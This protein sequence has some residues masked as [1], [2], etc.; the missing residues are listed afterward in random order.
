Y[1][2]SASPHGRSGN[3]VQL[4]YCP[5]HPEWKKIVDDD[6]PHFTEVA[7][8]ISEQNTEC[9]GCDEFVDWFTTCQASTI[10]YYGFGWWAWDGMIGNRRSCLAENHRHLPGKSDYA[11]FRGRT[12]MVRRLRK[13]FPDLWINVYWG[14]KPYGPWGLKDVDT[15]ENYFEIEVWDRLDNDETLA[16]DGR[17]QFFW[18]QNSRFLP[19]YKNYGHVN[20]PIGGGG[21]HRPDHEDPLNWVRTENTYEEGEYW[22]RY[23][24][25]VSLLSVIG[26]GSPIVLDAFPNDLDSPQGREVVDFY[27]KWFKWADENV[28]YLRKGRGIFGPPRIGHIDGQAHIINDRGFIFL[29]NMNQKELGGLLPIDDSL[30][31]GACGDYVLQEMYPCEGRLLCIDGKGIFELTWLGCPCLCAAR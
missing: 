2:G 18:N 16:H 8:W 21:A 15:H 31:I 22:D 1:L 4:D 17:G 13:E 9:H 14:L 28:E 11:E 30:G 26:T 19:P 24:W 23:G 25:K 5:D 29:F 27:R 20:H 10:R 7:S 3:S 12:A 6:E